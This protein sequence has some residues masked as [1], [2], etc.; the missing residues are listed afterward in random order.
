MSINL[1]QT[2]FS[3]LDYYRLM[4]LI[5][6]GINLRL[7]DATRVT[8]AERQQ[9]SDLQLSVHPWLFRGH[10][11]TDLDPVTVQ[12]DNQVEQI[13][14]I[15]RVIPAKM[16]QLR[17]DQMSSM[18]QSLSRAV[19]SLA[20]HEITAAA[21]LLRSGTRRFAEARLVGAA[22]SGWAFDIQS[23]VPEGRREPDAIRGR[24]QPSVSRVGA[25]AR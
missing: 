25:G 23:C 14:T 18:L 19:R 7:I 16:H 20:Q 5:S 8:D 4:L 9:T 15:V 1:S 22:A 10:L 6:I 2:L 11:L 21:I 17:P 24:E 12:L 13:T 3:R